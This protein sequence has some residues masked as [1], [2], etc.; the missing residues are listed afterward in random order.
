MA[1][2]SHAPQRGNE[3]AYEEIVRRY[4][5]VA[6]SDGILITGSAADPRMPRRRVS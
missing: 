1:R 6:F 3:A 5:D 4:Q 2:C